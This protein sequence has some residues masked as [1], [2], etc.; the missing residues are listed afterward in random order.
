MLPWYSGVIA[1]PSD[2]LD[3]F[4]VCTVVTFDAIS[5]LVR[6]PYLQRDIG[7]FDGGDRVAV[8]STL[9]GMEGRGMFSDGILALTQI[10]ISDEV[11]S[12]PH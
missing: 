4:K 6:E 8:C 12:P 5:G 1:N 10:R 3:N 9:Q 7:R 2:L 11:A